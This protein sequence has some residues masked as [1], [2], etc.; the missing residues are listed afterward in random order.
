MLLEVIALG[1]L[2]GV[3]PGTSHAA[4]IALLK[5]HEPRRPL[6]LFALAGSP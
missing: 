1:I 6:L 4:V 2:S 3:R 5:T